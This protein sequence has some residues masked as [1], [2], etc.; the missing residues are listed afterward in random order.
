LDHFF[1]K[2]L[3]IYQKKFAGILKL[4]IFASRFEKRGKLLEKAKKSSENTR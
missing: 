1:E 4:I 2:S 3:N